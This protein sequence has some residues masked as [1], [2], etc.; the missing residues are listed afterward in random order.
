MELLRQ[1]KHV[2]G[3]ALREPGSAQH[4]DRPGTNLGRGGEGVLPSILDVFIEERDEFS[5]DGLRGGSRDLVCMRKKLIVNGEDAWTLTYLLRYY[6]AYQ[7]S[8]RIN[9]LCQTLW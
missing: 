3:L 6:P 1:S 5:L 9:L 7:T 2:L 4:F 8:E